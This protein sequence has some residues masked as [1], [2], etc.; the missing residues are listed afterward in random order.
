MSARVRDR[1]LD[2]VVLGATGVTG[3]GVA[4]YLAERASQTDLRWAAAGR[5]PQRLSAALAELG[6]GVPETI[7]AD[8][9]DHNSL[10]A[11]AARA[12]VVLDLVGPYTDL[13]RPVIEACIAEGAHYVDLTGELPFVRSVIDTLHAGALQAGVK[14]VQICGFEALPPDLS[15]MLAAETARE[16]WQEG[17]ASVEV[18][19]SIAAPRGVPRPSDAISGGT[20]QSLLAVAAGEDSELILDPG[21]L[22]EDAGTAAAVRRAS[23]ITLAPRRGREGGVVAP[24]APAP[25]INPAVI[26]RSAAL[27]ETAAG[28][29]AAPFRYREGLLLRGPAPAMPLQWGLAA[30]LSATQVGL[31]GFARTP[32]P[33]R[34]RVVGGLSR[35]APA[36]GY[37]PESARMEA[38]H[39]RMTT[40]AT[41]V[42]GRQLTVVADADGHPGYLTTA[43]MLGEAG[44]LLAEDGV[45]PERAGC[46]TP[47]LALGTDCLERFDLARV[48]FSLS[49]P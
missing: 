9:G 1:D 5:N 36:S 44:I 35:L 47:A 10:R 13:G 7:L 20:L 48:R 33:L 8:V 43:R 40:Y 12:R 45:T 30:G 27:A 22:I 28:R 38:W 17:L 42:T 4:R 6:S 41:T 19:V 39:W 16:R 23:P 15:V 34:R 37:G 3:R 32:A 29:A 26:H 25:F 46:L 31:R 14:V 21:A 11:M 18:E 24:M 2:V 49:T